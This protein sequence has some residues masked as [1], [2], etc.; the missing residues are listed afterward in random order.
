MDGDGYFILTKKG[1]ASCEITMDTRD[2]QALFEIKQKYG[3]S[4]KPVSN[5]N[6]VRYKLRHRKGLILL[7]SDI[8]GHL[9]NPTRLLQM[10]KLCIKYNLELLYPEPL[11]FNNG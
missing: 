3:G 5:A 1:Y 7:I 2:K 6:A 9:R 11:T 10:N 8:N 4:I